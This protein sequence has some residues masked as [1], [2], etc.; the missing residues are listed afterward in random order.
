MGCLQ[1]ESNE[2]VRPEELSFEDGAYLVRL[3]RRSVEHHLKHKTPIDV[4][5]EASPR[6][7]RKGAAFVTINTFHTPSYRELRGCIGFI[8]PI[9]SLA[10]T[11]ATVALDAAFRDPRFPPLNENE[12]DY[13]TFEV[14]VLGP[15]EALPQDPR[16]RA[17]AITIGVHGLLV[18]RGLYQGVLLPEVPV[19]YLWDA[20]T[21]LAETCVKAGLDPSCWLDP[22]T[23]VYRFTART[24]REKTPRGEIEER[25]LR[26][27]YREALMRYANSED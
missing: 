25:D 12:L 26:R 27:E 1:V 9:K 5:R 23:E 3:A 19:E 16:G 15:L 4:R 21:F 6:L 14:T 8:A 22:R 13:V 24:W 7:M 10:E 17:K 20:E 18:R 2:Q 11:V